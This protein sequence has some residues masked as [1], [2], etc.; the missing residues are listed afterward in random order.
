MA[1]ALHDAYLL[2]TPRNVQ[3]PLCMFLFILYIPNVMRYNALY[4]NMLYC[5]SSVC[6]HRRSYPIAAVEFGAAIAFICSEI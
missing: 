6:G 1:L 3:A 2:G 5:S 4:N